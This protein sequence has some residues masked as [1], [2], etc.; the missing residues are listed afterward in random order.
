E[1]ENV[2]ITLRIPNPEDVLSNTYTFRLL[3]FSDGS[4]SASVFS[5]ENVEVTMLPADFI[6]PGIEY[7]AQYESPLGLIFPQ[8]PVNLGPSWRVYDMN[9]ASFTVYIDEIEYLTDVWTDGATISVPVTGSNPLSIGDHNIT[10]VVSD[11]AGNWGIDE[12]WV[13]IVSTDDVIPDILPIPTSLTLPANFDK[14]HV[15]SWNCTEEHLLNVTVY[16]NG[17]EVPL[18][19]LMIEKEHDATSTFQVYCRLDPA[20]ISIGV[21]NYTVLIQDMGGNSNTSSIFV[22]IASED[23]VSPVII[24]SPSSVYYLAHNEVLSLTSTDAYPATYELWLNSTLYQNGTWQS[25]VSIDIN[26]DDLNISVG[27]YHI[28]FYVYDQSGNYDLYDDWFN[29]QDIDPPTAVFTPPSL[30]INEHQL[31]NLLG[32]EW[33]LHDFDYRPGTYQIMLDFNLYDEGIWT[34][35]NPTVRIPLIGLTAGSYHFNVY[36]ED[37]TGNSL[38]SAVDVAVKDVLAP[39]IWPIDPILFEPIYTASWFE[40]YVTD[41][42]LD[43]YQLFRN[44]ALIFEGDIISNFPFLLVDLSDLPTGTYEYVLEVTDESNNLG[45]ETVS[46][47]VD[48]SYPPFIK[49]PQDLI[50]SEGTTGHSLTW[51]IL[52]AYPKNYSLYMNGVLIDSGTYLTE[53][54]TTNVDGLELGIY[55]FT[56]IVEDNLGFSHAAACYVVVVDITAPLLTHLGNFRF[57]VGDPN[58]K[59]VWKAEDSHPSH[60]TITVNG[61]TNPNQKWYG[62]DII[63]QLRTWQDVGTY[64]VILEVSD[65]SG[66]VASDRVEITIVAEEDVHSSAAPSLTS[67][68]G[69]ITLAMLILFSF[70]RLRRGPV[71]KKAKLT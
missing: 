61:N 17:S 66:N 12:V 68:S 13:T 71:R 48:D 57:E 55:E 31:S 28:Q 70:I 11:A 50:Y 38:I 30:T 63:L 3:A 53:N 40:F 4:G 25:G 51:T 69:M 46:V 35:G 33:Q 47:S 29:Y 67:V 1:T 20:S 52:E 44:G 54:L 64:E 22:T 45:K 23:F 36:F 49:R 24:S 19:H 10:L 41:A 6:A 37:A 32:P 16:R 7:L 2:T 21:W 8:S 58:A 42:H 34:I 43:T 59:L 27:V 18:N 9:P 26:V 15:I 60:Y 5:A 65:M 62:Q 39:Y 56:L 14:K